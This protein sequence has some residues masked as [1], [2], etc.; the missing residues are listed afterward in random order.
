MFGYNLEEFTKKNA[1]EIIAQGAPLLILED[2]N[3]E[4]FQLIKSGNYIQSF[5]KRSNGE[6]FPIEIS[7]SKMK[8]FDEVVLLVVVRDITEKVKAE[9]KLNRY[10]EDLENRVQLRTLELAESN[11]ALKHE[12][13]E[14]LKAREKIEYVAYHDILTG[15]PNRLLLADRVNQSIEISKRMGETFAMLSLDLDYF[16]LVNNSMGHKSGDELLK[17]VANRLSKLIRSSDTL[18]RTFGDQF[19]I[20]VTNIKDAKDVLKVADKI[21]EKF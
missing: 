21:I 6:V 10:H 19:V 20:M 4:E 16:N 17:E 8:I 1:Q 5:N 11:I 7:A 15:L 2:E 3:T 18:C 14:H 9:D 12:I 13:E